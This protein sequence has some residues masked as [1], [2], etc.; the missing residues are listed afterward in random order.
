MRTR[1]ERRIRVIALAFGL[2]AFSFCG[3]RAESPGGAFSS[4]D[5]E[6]PAVAVEHHEHPEI[7]VSPELQKSWGLRVGEVRRE[8]LAGL[9]TVPGTI[10]L[11]ENRTAHVSSFVSGQIASVEADLGLEVRKG[12]PLLTIHSPEF[13]RAQ[14]DFLDAKA[15]YELGLADFKRAEALWQAKAIEEKEYLRRRAENEKLATEYGVL[16]SKLHSLGLTHEDIEK[17]IEKCRLV[18]TQQYKCELADPNLVIF[19]T[20]SGTVIFRNAVVGDPV[21]PNKVLFT[22]SDL[23]AL[24]AYLDVPEKDIPFVGANSRVLLRSGLFPGRDFT[25][26]INHISDVV[27][28]K[29]RT[30]RI[31]AEVDGAAGLLKPNMYIQG[32]IEHAAPDWTGVL[33]LPE[34]AVQTLESEKVVFVREKEGVFAARPVR[35]GER[36]GDRRIILDGL[37]EGETVVLEG[38]FTLK[39]ELTKAAAGHAHVH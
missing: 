18:E 38:A 2:L 15:R 14:A 3:R 20:L 17:L 28:E 30:L 35:I 1:M 5:E 25:S 19:A 33:A 4:H 34:A 7:T 31:R 39:S 29:L 13:A 22:I 26:K 8:T 11:N 12:Q 16:G 10:V 23:R 21:E 32:I 9:L 24:W 27:D 36:V 6:S 37:A